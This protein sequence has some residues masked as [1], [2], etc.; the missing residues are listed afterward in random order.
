MDRP[1]PAP[2]PNGAVING[3]ANKIFFWT[4]LQTPAR[5]QAAVPA[6]IKK[7]TSGKWSYKVHFTVPDSLQI[8]A[9]VPITLN[10][11]K[12]TG[13]EGVGRRH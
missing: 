8:V 1:S 6:T 2:S 10:T 3:G 5:V 13:R 11:L 12:V 4:V 7:D 9:G